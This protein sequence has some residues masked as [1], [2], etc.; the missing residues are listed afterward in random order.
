MA[1]FGVRVRGYLNWMSRKRKF[2]GSGSPMAR[3]ATMVDGLLIFRNWLDLVGL[4]GCYDWLMKVEEGTCQR[5]HVWVGC[6]QGIWVWSE[7]FS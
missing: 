3:G 7:D 5:I 6:W 2:R 4:I 1:L